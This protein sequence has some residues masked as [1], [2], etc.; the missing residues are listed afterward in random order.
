MYEFK[1]LQ[2]AVANRLATRLGLGT[3]IHQPITLAE[4]Y[5]FDEETYIKTKPEIGFRK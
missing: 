2:P 4:L 3:E 5:N 1:P